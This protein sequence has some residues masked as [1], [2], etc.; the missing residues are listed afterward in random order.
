LG[1]EHRFRK[2]HR[3]ERKR[4]RAKIEPRAADQSHHR[5]PCGTVISSAYLQSLIARLVRNPRCHS[6]RSDCVRIHQ[7][8]C[9]LEPVRQA[10]G[11][12]RERSCIFN[13]IKRKISRLRLE[14]TSFH[15]AWLAKN[16]VPETYSLDTAGGALCS[17][18]PIR[19]SAR[20]NRSHSCRP[21]SFH[22]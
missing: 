17:T 20:Q 6:E 9:H 2:K 5:F 7:P 14:M 10:Q 13:Y 21:V 4:V 22:A 1:S 15:T 11:K 16:L 12:L 3:P 8:I 18:L 19:N